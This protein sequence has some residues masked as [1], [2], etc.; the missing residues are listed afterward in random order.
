MP[1]PSSATV[2][3]RAFSCWLKAIVTLLALTVPGGVV[4]GLLRD[5]IKMQPVLR[6]RRLWVACFLKR[7]RQTRDARGRARQVLQRDREAR[8]HPCARARG[9]GPNPASAPRLRW[10]FP[11]SAPLWRLRVVRRRAVHSPGKSPRNRSP[12]DAAQDRRVNRAR[13]VAA[14]ARLRGGFRVPISACVPA[15]RNPRPRTWSRCV[16]T[17]AAPTATT[18]K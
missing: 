8:V 14:R 7:D 9:R 6:V 5:S 2:K 10:P 3:S 16:F 18:A 15:S 13:C 17:A 12:P 11:E 1:L 4:H